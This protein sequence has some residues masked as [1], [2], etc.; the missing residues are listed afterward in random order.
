MGIDLGQVRR[1]ALSTVTVTDCRK[2]L[3]LDRNDTLEMAFT[4]SS[5]STPTLAALLPRFLKNNF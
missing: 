3:H 2:E 5:E 4:L 1:W